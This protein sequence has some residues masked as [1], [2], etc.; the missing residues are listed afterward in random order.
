MAT[1]EEKNEAAAKMVAEI[2]RKNEEREKNVF[3]QNIWHSWQKVD[4][5]LGTWYNTV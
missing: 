4:Q 5:T 2:I 1:T 3:A